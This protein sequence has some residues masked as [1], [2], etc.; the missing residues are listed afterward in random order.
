MKR[1]IRLFIYGKGQAGPNGVRVGLRPLE[2]YGGRAACWNFGVLVNW[3]AL[4]VGAHYSK[5][6]QRLC[7][8]PVPCVTIWVC[9]PYGKLP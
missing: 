2:S 9:K 3:K 5:S 4:W 1:L 7:V 6:D 8:N